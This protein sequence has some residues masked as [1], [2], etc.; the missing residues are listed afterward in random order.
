MITLPVWAFVLIIFVVFLLAIFIMA[1][2][3][4][5]KLSE[6]EAT[7]KKK[8]DQIKEGV[9]S[10]NKLNDKYIRLNNE[11]TRLIRVNNMVNTVKEN[12]PEQIKKQSKN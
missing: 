11:H 6:Y 2:L 5:N 3:T 7:I 4:E 12:V 8:N 1:S 9:S 10:Y